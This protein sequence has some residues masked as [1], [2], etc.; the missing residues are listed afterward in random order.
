MIRGLL[1][2]GALVSGAAGS[3]PAAAHG[4][5][6]EFEVAFAAAGPRAE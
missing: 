1:L 6:G 4:C 2:C 3:V 5:R